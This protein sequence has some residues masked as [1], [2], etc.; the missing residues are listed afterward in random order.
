MQHSRRFS[1]SLNACLCTIVLLVSTTVVAQQNQGSS[2]KTYHVA[3]A[4]HMLEP[5]NT[6]GNVGVFVGDDGVLLIDDHFDFSV[7]IAVVVR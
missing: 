3:G 6:N 2:F 1:I 7:E 5:A 4:V